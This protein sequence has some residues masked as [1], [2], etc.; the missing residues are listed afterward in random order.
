MAILGE[1]YTSKD[2]NRNYM[3]LRTNMEIHTNNLLVLSDPHIRLSSN[4]SSLKPKKGELKAGES[5]FLPG[6]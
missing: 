1:L 3:I 4:G 6:F 5:D 2:W